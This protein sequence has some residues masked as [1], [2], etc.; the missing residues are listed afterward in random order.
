MSFRVCDYSPL[1]FEELRLLQ[2]IPNEMFLESFVGPS[3]EETMTKS[4]AKSDSYFYKTADERFLIKT[5]VYPEV[6]A[7][8]SL[9]KDYYKHLVMYPKSFLV[10]ICGMWRIKDDER[11]D[12]WIIVMKN[13]FPPSFKMEETYDLKGRKAKPGSK[14]A[15][16]GDVKRDN[17]YSPILFQEEDKLFF[18]S[19]I[20]H[21]V[22]LLRS[23]KMMDYSLLIGI[24]T[25]PLDAD[26]MPSNFL[27]GDSF[28]NIQ[29]SNSYTLK[30]IWI[31]IIDILTVYNT[32]KKIANLF[33]T[34][35]FERDSLSTV[36]SE[37]YATRFLNFAT[38]SLIN[39]EEDTKLPQQNSTTSSPLPPDLKESPTLLSPPPSLDQLNNEM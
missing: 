15:T 19:Q 3:S 8:L 32:Q 20:Q 38:T 26:S 21:D 22:E 23:H 16:E 24:H 2:G 14:L 30:Y 27:R 10:K 11:E 1:V 13:T 29:N 25:G 28:R 31:N 18:I 5:I 6:C 35:L 7:L 39:S 37:F 17:Q 36:D 34:K 33:K 4:N 9:L 12:I